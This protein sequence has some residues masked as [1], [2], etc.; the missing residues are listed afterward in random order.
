MMPGTDGVEVCGVI[1]EIWSAHR[2]QILIL[3]GITAALKINVARLLEQSLADS[4]LSKPYKAADPLSESRLFIK[5][6]E[7][8]A[9]ANQRK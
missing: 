8:K 3:L 5:R 6:I 1:T 4:F 9:I 2:P 7:D